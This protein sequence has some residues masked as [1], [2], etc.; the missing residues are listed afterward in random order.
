MS[1]TALGNAAANVDAKRMERPR[2][3]R[4][5]K[6]FI[7]AP[8]VRADER[9]NSLM[10]S[11]AV[12]AGA[13]GPVDL[14]KE[15]GGGSFRSLRSRFKPDLKHRR[16]L[17]RSIPSS[18]AA[19]CSDMPRSLSFE[20]TSSCR[21]DSFF[22]CRAICA[23]KT[24]LACSGI[25]IGSVAPPASDVSTVSA[26]GTGDWPRGARRAAFAPTR[27]A[28]RSMST[29]ARP[30]STSCSHLS[31]ARSIASSIT[32]RE[33]VT[34]L[35]PLSA[36]LRTIRIAFSDSMAPRVKQLSTTIVRAQ[37]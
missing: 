36:A 14:P 33:V 25:A 30:A 31:I 22:L 3:R 10:K 2:V 17:E 34:D 29:M 35:A 23:R 11:R 19:R 4:R 27:K 18:R 24:L 9:V 13:E 7:G 5:E 26:S 32:R 1:I 28:H 8:Q 12:V 20:R 21:R 37:A 15:G 16:M 6:L